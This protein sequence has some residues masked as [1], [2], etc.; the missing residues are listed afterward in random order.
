MTFAVILHDLTGQAQPDDRAPVDVGAEIQRHALAQP[1]GPGEGLVAAALG[2][3]VQHRQGGVDVGLWLAFD[4]VDAEHLWAPGELAGPQVDVPAPHGADAL[5]QL[6]KQLA[7]GQCR[8]G[9]PPLG[10]VVQSDQ[11]HRVAVEHHAPHPHV[12]PEAAFADLKRHFVLPEPGVVE[13]GHHVVG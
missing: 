6:E 8:H 10:D 5:G 3:R 2:L 4:A 12:G 1:P 11:G 13:A 9:L 7:A